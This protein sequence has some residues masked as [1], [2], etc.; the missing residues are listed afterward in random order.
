MDVNNES[1]ILGLKPINTF[2]PEVL[3]NKVPDPTK[4]GGYQLFPDLYCN[5]ALISKKKSGKT[6]LLY[7]ILK[8]C[9][10]KKTKVFLFS[11]TIEIDATY[12]HILK[13]LDSKKVEYVAKSH[14]IIDGVNMVDQIMREYGDIGSS[15]KLKQEEKEKKLVLFPER[16]KRAPKKPKIEYPKL[17]VCFDDMGEELKHRSVRQFARTHRHYLSKLLISTQNLTDIDPASFL[18]FDY[19]ILFQKFFEEKLI[20][21][22]YYMGLS[23][24]IERFLEMYRIAT[25]RPFHFL[26]VDSRR[27]KYRINF[28]TEFSGV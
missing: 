8:E 9:V 4:I 16:R 15:D 10:G 27:D 11:P 28:N 13:M 25:C 20:R 7:N 26:F 2:V 18:Q 22:H 23:A 1:S 19:V 17:I 14:F 24:T 12:Q 3:I 21:I 6:N 5:I